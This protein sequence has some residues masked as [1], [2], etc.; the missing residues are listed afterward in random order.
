MELVPWTVVFL[1]RI[2]PPPALDQATGSKVQDAHL[3]FLAAQHDAGR[4]VAAGPVRS[5][6][7][8]DLAGICLYH[9][10]RDEA[11]A[12]AEQDPAVQRGVFRVETLS[13]LVPRGALEAGRGA[14]PR[15]MKDVGAP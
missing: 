15:S 14:F 10:D 5:A 6:E 12:L 4:L 8:G 11:K 9:V 2:D 3:A 7:G 1:R 13:W